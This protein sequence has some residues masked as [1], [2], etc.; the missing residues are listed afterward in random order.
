MFGAFVRISDAGLGCPDWPGCY[1]K[2][3]PFGAMER[4]PRR[5]ARA[6]P[7]AGYRLQGLGRDAASLRGE[8]AR[9]C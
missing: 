3:T 6:T 5:G 2:V 7:R 9:A 1:G 4:H 8:R